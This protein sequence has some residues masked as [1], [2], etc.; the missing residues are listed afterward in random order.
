MA[1]L[2]CQPLAD[3]FFGGLKR[4][5]YQKKIKNFKIPSVD[6]TFTEVEFPELSLEEALKVTEKYS[7][8]AKTAAAE[9]KDT[10]PTQ[11]HHGRLRLTIQFKI[12]L[13]TF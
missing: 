1:N 8:E 7:T 12:F 2:S 11:R 4:Y 6:D 10:R 9:R 5:C 3:Y 13:F